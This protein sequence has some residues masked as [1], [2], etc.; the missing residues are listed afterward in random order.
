M[1]PL[2]AART[3]LIEQLAKLH[4]AL[5][6]VGPAR[7]PSRQRS[8]DPIAFGDLPTSALTL[9]SRPGSSSPARPTDA[10]GSLKPVIV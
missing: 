8:I 6:G 10:V 5:L 3:V 2:L 1:E 7:A 4:L 9:A